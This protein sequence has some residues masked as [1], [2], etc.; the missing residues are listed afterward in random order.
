MHVVSR[1]DLGKERENNE[2]SI[3]IDAD[4]GI[5]LLADGMGGHHGGEVASKI[6]VNEAYNYLAKHLNRIDSGND[7]AKQLTLALFKAHDAVLER[8]QSDMKLL[9]MG[10]TLAEMTIKNNIAYVCH[11]GDSR[12]Y[13]IRDEIKQI[14]KDHTLGDYLVEQN[15]ITEEKVPAQNWHELTQ[16]VGAAGSIVP[17]LNEIPLKG[18]DVILICSDGLTDMLVNKEI[19]AFIRGEKEDLD[20]SADALIAAANERGGRDN[21]SII[22]IRYD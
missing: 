11:V 2:D 5:F 4:K 12:V 22:L 1:S 3:L 10:T 9:G 20:G 7:I 18:D 13:L 19:E 16:C 21:I 14:T 6:A 17:E 15:I 8:A